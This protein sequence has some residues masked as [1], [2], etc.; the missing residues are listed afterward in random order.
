MPEGGV[1]LEKLT[2]QGT[3]I[4][5]AIENVIHLI[6]LVSGPSGPNKFVDDTKPINVPEDTSVRAA[7]PLG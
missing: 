5:G 7:D 4:A 1:M 6:A 3:K 2:R